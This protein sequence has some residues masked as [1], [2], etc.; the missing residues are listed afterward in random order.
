[1]TRIIVFNAEEIIDKH[2]LHVHAQTD[3][4]MTDIQLTVNVKIIIFL[5]KKKKKKLIVDFQIFK[6][7]LII[8]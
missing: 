8:K 6:I 5:K 7:V 3:F 1:V 2:L 4:L